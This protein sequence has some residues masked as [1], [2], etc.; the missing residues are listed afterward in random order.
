MLK[1]RAHTAH[2]QFFIGL[3]F[4]PLGES[5]KAHTKGLW[6]LPTRLLFHFPVIPTLSYPVMGLW[7]E[8]SRLSFT[9]LSVFHCVR[10]EEQFRTRQ[11]QEI[12][13]GHKLSLQASE[14][15]KDGFMSTFHKNQTVDISG[16]PFLFFP[17][18]V[19]VSF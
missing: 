12:Y 5:I 14:S 16:F 6:P 11:T 13:S 8:K 19:C 4:V 10:Q 3:A 2:A 15:K 9:E 18:R 7:M 1:P 17:R